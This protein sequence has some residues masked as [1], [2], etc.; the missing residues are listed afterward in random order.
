MD[1]FLCR[2][3]FP[4]PVVEAGAAA[5]RF[6]GEARFDGCIAFTNRPRV[7][8]EQ[9]L[10]PELRLVAHTAEAPDVHPVTFMF[11]GLRNTT[12]LF[13]GVAIP[14]G[15]DYPELVMAIPFVTHRRG[16]H[17]HTYVAR[18]YSSVPTSVFVGNTYYGFAKSLA[19][20]RWE[21]QIFTVASADESQLLL[22]A[23]VERG[24]DGTR[25]HERSIPNLTSMQAA[26]SL[27]ILG[28][29]ADGSLVSSYFGLDFNAG[30]VAAA[31]SCISIAA[32]IVEG[33]IPG[34]WFDAPAGTVWVRD[35]MWR[36][37]WP[38]PGRF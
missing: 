36:L 13:G 11:G 38:F 10:P 12:I 27:P 20:M 37:S 5:E 3:A 18:M 6:M 7:E 24:G 25:A 28:R 32:P 29:R 14:T 33:L 23:A 31:D 30:T 22:H 26:L 9:L 1:R 35:V 16:R 4:G 21:G 15:V 19:T 8:I 2:E 34:R 17:L